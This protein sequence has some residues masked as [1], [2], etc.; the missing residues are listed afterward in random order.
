MEQS[1]GSHTYMRPSIFCHSSHAE[2]FSR[3]SAKERNGGHRIPSSDHHVAIGDTINPCEPCHWDLR[4]NGERRK[5]RRLS[6]PS[7]SRD[8]QWNERQPWILRVCMFHFNYWTGLKIDLDGS[9][10]LGGKVQER[11]QDT[12]FFSYLELWYSIPVDFECSVSISVLSP[13]CILS[14]L[15]SIL[16]FP[17]RGRWIY[18]SVDFPPKKV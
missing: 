10:K 6:V 11:D 4:R 16:N 2:R 1:V 17:S 8:T 15:L 9:G 12:L 5:E 3:R 7:C 14:K 13:H 18:P